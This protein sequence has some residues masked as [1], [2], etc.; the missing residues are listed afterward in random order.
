M[1][2]RDGVSFGDG[3]GFG[4]VL[5]G[6]GGGGAGGLSTCDDSTRMVGTLFSEGAG[7]GTGAGATG[8]ICVCIVRALRRSA[9]PAHKN[10]TPGM[11]LPNA[12]AKKPS[13]IPTSE[14]IPIPPNTRKPSQSVPRMVSTLPR[15]PTG[16]M[17][18]SATD[19]H[20]NI[21]AG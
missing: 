15:Q 19:A 20:S 21:K 7:G 5:T 16:L 14:R 18:W 12:P 4:A 13:L 8:S 17:F 3:V 1:G 2:S 10:R 6:V 9:R 11:A